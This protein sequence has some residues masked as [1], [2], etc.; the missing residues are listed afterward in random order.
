VWDAENLTQA[1]WFEKYFRFVPEYEREH[2]AVLFWIDKKPLVE[3]VGEFRQKL[4]KTEPYFAEFVI[5][6]YH[7]RY[8]DR[9]EAV[10]AYRKCLSLGTGSKKD[11]WLTIRAKSRLY[12]LT[13]QK[14]QVKTSPAVKD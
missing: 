5:A 8:G 4:G 1:K 11:Q 14:Q 9:N 3:K 2:K 13:E 7:L 6:E 12:D 10:K